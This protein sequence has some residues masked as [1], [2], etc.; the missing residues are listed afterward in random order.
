M[1]DKEVFQKLLTMYSSGVCTDHE[2]REM[3]RLLEENPA[4]YELMDTQINHDWWVQSLTREI[5]PEDPKP[6]PAPGTIFR[7]IGPWSVA[8]GF[9]ILIAAGL[10]WWLP[11]TTPDVLEYSTGYGE[12]Q[13][14]ELPDGS[15]VEMN[16]N[17]R[18]VWDANWEHSGNR[19]VT[20]DG[21]AYFDVVK[22]QNKKF[23][24]KRSNRY[25]YPVARE[26][27]KL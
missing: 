26:N 1:K 5:D 25:C 22:A 15:K 6:E 2:V 21:E 17:S 16:A 7:R 19:S 12:R 9:L 11:T 23:Q 3:V 8:A 18:L 4:L 27:P 20:L 14:I 24:V 13:K 10:L